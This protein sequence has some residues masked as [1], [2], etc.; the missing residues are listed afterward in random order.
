[1]RISTRFIVTIMIYVLL[2]VLVCVAQPDVVFD[3][4]GVIRPFGLAT[5]DGTLFSLGVV[6][7]TAA[8]VSFFIVMLVFA[9]RSSPT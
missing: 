9:V 6:T 7:V 8:F 5:T 4:N 3:Q 2:M 1:M